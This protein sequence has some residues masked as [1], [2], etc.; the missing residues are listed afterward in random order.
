[1]LARITLCVATMWSMSARAQVVVH[2]EGPDAAKVKVE[3]LEAAPSGMSAVESQALTAALGSSSLG[4]RINGPKRGNLVAELVKAGNDIGAR[5][6]IVARVSGKSVWILA[7]DASVFI[8]PDDERFL[9][10]DQ[11][12]PE[13]DADGEGGGDALPRQPSMPDP[14]RDEEREDG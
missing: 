1:M 13:P 9:E 11:L 6:V 8:Q 12:D 14:E 7:V 3:I 2:V 4:D 5:V 10:Y